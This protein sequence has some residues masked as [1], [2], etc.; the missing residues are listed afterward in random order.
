MAGTGWKGFA[1]CPWQVEAARWQKNAG[2]MKQRRLFRKFCD[3]VPLLVTRARYQLA[4][5]HDSHPAI[6]DRVKV[7]AVAVVAPDPGQIP[8]R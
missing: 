3:T 8:L 5:G 1:R 6:F 7:L 2:A 4:F